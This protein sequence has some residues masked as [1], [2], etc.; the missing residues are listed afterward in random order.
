[1]TW[2]VVAVALVFWACV[3]M[4]YFTSA[5]TTP[6]DFFLGRYEEPPDLGVWKEVGVDRDSGLLREER[7]LLPDG[8]SRAS[9]LLRQVRFREPATRNIVRVEPEQKVARRRVGRASR[10]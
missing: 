5:G 10:G 8:S 6:I 3:F 4:V 1:M 9:F 2:P 7:H